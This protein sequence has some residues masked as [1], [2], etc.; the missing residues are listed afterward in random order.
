MQ[1]THL[2][3]DHEES[4]RKRRKTETGAREKSDKYEFINGLSLWSTGTQFHWM[5]F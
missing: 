1:I 5:N 4:E 3:D 2:G